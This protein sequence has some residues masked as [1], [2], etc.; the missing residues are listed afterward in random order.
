[1][2]LEYLDR[3]ESEEEA[4]CLCSDGGGR[5]QYIPLSPV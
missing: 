1:M 2:H 3:S 5:R 4:V